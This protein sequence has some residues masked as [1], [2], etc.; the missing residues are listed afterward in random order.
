MG[1]VAGSA[2]H[3]EALNRGRWISLLLGFAGVLLILRPG[4][5]LINPASLVMLAG[6]SVSAF[7][8]S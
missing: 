7:L 6:P 2:V 8:R 1:G 4:T 5:A 3:G